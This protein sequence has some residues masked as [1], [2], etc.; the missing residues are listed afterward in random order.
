MAKRVATVRGLA[1]SQPNAISPAGLGLHSHVIVVLKYRFDAESD[2]ELLVV[3]GDILKLVDRPGNGWLVV[4][5]LDKMHPPGLIPSSYVDIAVNDPVNPVTAAWLQASVPVEDPQSGQSGSGSALNCSGSAPEGP[6]SVHNTPENAQ[7]DLESTLRGLAISTDT[8]PSAEAA[9][10]G[11]S[12]PNSPLLA[13]KAPKTTSRPT[14]TSASISN[15]L[16]FENRYWYR[17][18]IAYSDGSRA[19]ICRYYQD[20]YN[21]HISLLDTLNALD[22]SE[23]AETLRLPK[24]PEPIPSKRCDPHQL[25][26][27]LLKR[28]NDLH[29]YMNRLILN[30]NY[31][32]SPQLVS[33]LDTQYG[34]LPGFSVAKNEPF[35]MNNDQINEKVL[36]HSVNILL[37]SCAEDRVLPNAS[38]EP[39]PR[40]TKSKNTFNHYHQAS[41]LANAR[42]TSQGGPSP[43]LR[44]NTALPDPV[45]DPAPSRSALESSIFSSAPNTPIIPEPSV[46]RN[47]AYARGSPT[48]TRAY[49]TTPLSTPNTSFSSTFSGSPTQGTSTHIKCKIMTPSTDIVAIKLSKNDI[50]SVADLKRL[51]LRK[52]FFSHLHIRLPH[53][54]D[55]VFHD[56]DSIGLNLQAFLRAHDKVLLKVT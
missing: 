20:F 22:A 9:D 26:N 25:V 34:G 15:F 2:H 41:Q 44:L 27:M 10:P 19:Y 42:K 18:D 32:G 21:L 1:I 13:E 49:Q 40:R 7:N 14:P 39:L 30:K 47:N 48:A 51:L 54:P 45:P 33:W 50:G 36:P 3:K 5:F 23:I 8:T 12:T 35:A 11:T 6:E 16:L 43:V 28:C 24:L 4:K 55:K 37:E 53:Q 31:Q 29:V 38:E 17:V 56:I 46:G 52:I